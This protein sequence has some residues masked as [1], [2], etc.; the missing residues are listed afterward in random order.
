MK[1]MQSLI[2]AWLVVSWLSFLYF[3]T[4]LY[5]PTFETNLTFP[6]QAKANNIELTFTWNYQK[7]EVWTWSQK[8]SWVFIK[9]TNWKTI[10]YFH[11]NWWNLGYFKDELD[12][13]NSLWYNVMSYDYPWYWESD[14]FPYED[15]VTV[16]SQKFYDEVEFDKIVLVSPLSS[17]YDMW[18]HLYNFIIQ[19]VFLKED[20]FI[21]KE[22]VKTLKND[23]LIIHGDKDRV[24]PLKQGKLV[25]DNFASTNKSFI[26]I[27]D[28]WHSNIL[29]N[30]W[31]WLKNVFLDFLTGSSKWVNQVK[32]DDNIMNTNI[33][34]YWSWEL[35][36]IEKSFLNKF[37]YKKDDSCT[38]YVDPK[39]SYFDMNY[40]PDDLVLLETN[41]YLNIQKPDTKL[42][43]QAAGCLDVMAKKYF[44]EKAKKVQ[45]VS[46]F[47]DFNYQKRILDR[48]CSLTLCSKPWFSEHQSWL[49]LDFGEATTNDEFLSKAE[50]REFFVWM[51]ENAYKY[52][53]TNS[54]KKW[55]EIDGYQIEPWHWRYVWIELATFLSENNY[56]FWEY[57]KKL[58]E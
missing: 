53:Y 11:W 34:S 45:V 1:K 17:R 31:V 36:L 57:M 30:Y 50:F 6:K 29:S 16:S 37:D 8:I 58:V 13:I 42:R 18:S 2:I 22:K 54:Y 39:V 21:N 26:E 14:W 33:I 52:W 23:V 38:K 20:S 5:F 41:E 25:F 10:Y 40:V 3:L 35:K 15:E 9:W 48:W 28:L 44:E 56:S 47:R 49:A 19:K 43:K 32:I 24:I 7:I 4:C 12:Y 51:N 27:D 46:A 55:V